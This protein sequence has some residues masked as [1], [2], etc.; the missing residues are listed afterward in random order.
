MHIRIM[1]FILAAS[2]TAPAAAQSILTF[3]PNNDTVKDTVTFRLT[4]D[5]NAKISRWFFEIKDETGLLIKEFK[6]NGR[7]PETL[8][9]GGTD[10]NNRLVTDGV[11]RYSLNLQTPAGN[12]VAIAPSQLIVDRV[13]PSAT[14]SV[15]PL[16]FSP[17]GDGVK[18]EAQFNLA[19]DDANQIHSWMLVIKDREGAPARTITG[20][21]TPPGAIRFDGRGDFEEDLPDGS[22]TF[23]LT[24][25]DRAGNK[26]TT[27]VKHIA[28]DRAGQVSTVEVIPLLFSPNG[29]G[30]RDIVTFKIISA[31][32]TAVEKWELTLL[33]RNGKPVKRFAGNGTPPR[34]ILWDGRT[35]KK[36][37]AED[38]PY[39]VL[40][41]ETDNAGNSA[42]TTPQPLEIDTAPPLV[43]ALLEPDLLSP[44]GD[45]NKDEG[46]FHLKAEDVSALESWAL[47]I[48]NDVGRVMH[49]V[50]GPKGSKP[51]K[52]MTWK[53]ED[54]KQAPLVDGTYSYFLEARDIGGNYAKTDQRPVRIDRAPPRTTITAATELFSPN[55]DGVLD[56]QTFTLSVQDASPLEA[57]SVAIKDEKDKI[58]RSFI[59]PPEA[60]PST[61]LWD[62][63]NDSRM[64]LPDG[65]Y[66]YTLSA[67]DIVGNTATSAPQKMIIGATRPMP[68]VVSDLRAFSPNADNFKDVAKLS[69]SVKSFN[70]IKEWQLKIFDKIRDEGAKPQ[71]IFFGRG[72]V[73]GSLTWKGDSDDK[74]ALPDGEY[75][76]I[77]AVLDEAGNSVSTPA[78]LI[79]IDTTKPTLKISV[80]PTL[81]SPN[82]DGAQDEA[83]FMLNYTDA[84]PIESWKIVVMDGGKETVWKADGGKKLP[85]SEAWAGRTT[86]GEKLRDGAY[87]YI[88]SAT[89]EV[90]NTAITP[91]QIARIDTTPPQISLQIKPVLF[92]PNGDGVKD[93][94]TFV[95][96]SED[97]SDISKW[98]IEILNAESLP[99]RTFTGI[100]R[101]PKSF[102]WD[103]RNDHSSTVED[104]KYTVALS[105]TDEVANTG[106][107]AS[108]HVTVDTAKPL[109]TVEAE[110]DE[111]EYLIPEM[112]VT[113]TKVKDLVISLSSEILFDTGQANIKSAAYP[114]LMKATHLIRRYPLRS[115]RVEG[116]ADNVPIHNEEF[117]NNQALSESRAKAIMEFFATRGQV[118]RERM[119]AF[120]F[121]DDRPKASNE[122][123]SGRRQNRRVEII[124]KKEGS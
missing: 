41:A 86:K 69:L 89:D 114:T 72:D 88:F 76:Y 80:S 123:P 46:I 19:A 53:G 15:E 33:N 110:T 38:G 113:Q 107:N 48:L 93:E 24:V 55:G 54:E 77:L 120:G 85:L 63:K 94:T 50:T 44:N 39:S 64:Q 23:E 84:S 57:W 56:S 73:P 116:H 122:T 79:R 61:I 29:D 111:L 27:P 83:V 78:Q 17:N 34:E 67:R 68:K 81:F 99:V 45:K 25:H 75:E 36:K 31:G 119:Q 30:I 70:K 3:S 74:R 124:L 4:L 16:I 20:R 82:K 11:Y 65:P 71:R 7:P 104:G 100:G 62:G 115:I 108:A 2:L 105:I 26:I 98:I 59:G 40:L 49:T 95:L 101:P 21:G 52:T 109:I 28:I 9:W 112:S 47:K 1:T 18:D 43:E 51:R 103:G 37:Q 66:T 118:K 32:V 96:D 6:G 35:D 91:E 60:V 106:R 22:Y 90:G 14:A 58:V 13:H 102:P 8:S 97:A 12:Q 10:V 87:N 117:K 92:S 42:Q 5:P 121:G